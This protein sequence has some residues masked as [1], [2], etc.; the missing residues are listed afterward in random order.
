MI[1]DGGRVDIFIE[2]VGY[3]VSLVEQLKSEGI[4]AEGV[5]LHGEDKTARLTRISMEIINGF[6]QFPKQGVCLNFV[7]Y[8]NDGKI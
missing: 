5:E 4:Y 7:G 2:K 8:K 6:V 3:Q 1:N